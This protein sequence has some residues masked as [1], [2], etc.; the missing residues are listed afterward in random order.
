MMPVGLGPN[1]PALKTP[2]C[3]GFEMAERGAV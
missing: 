3:G 2:A 1:R